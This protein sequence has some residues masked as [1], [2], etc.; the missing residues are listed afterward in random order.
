[1]TRSVS[2]RANIVWNNSCRGNGS[3]E[4][5]PNNV[6]LEV[7]EIIK[8]KSLTSVHFAIFNIKN[9]IQKMRKITIILRRV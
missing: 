8:N 9:A 1:V 6:N 5:M 3:T 4:A 7:L 2:T